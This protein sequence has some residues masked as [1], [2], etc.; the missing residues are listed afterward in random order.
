MIV[1]GGFLRL[2]PIK[3]RRLHRTGAKR[4]HGNPARAPLLR[5]RARKMLDRSFGTRINGIRIRVGGEQRRNDRDYFSTLAQG[6]SRFLQ[7]E[8][9]T[10]R[11]DRETLIVVLFRA[12]ENWF[13][14]HH[15]RGVDGDVHPAEAALG[16]GEQALVSR[17]LGEIALN[18]ERID[19][20]GFDRSDRLVR[21]RLRFGAVVMHDN[22]L[23]SVLREVPTD[24]TSEILRAAA[25][26]DNLILERVGHAPFCLVPINR[27]FQPTLRRHEFWIKMVYLTPLV[28]NSEQCDCRTMDKFESLRIFERVAEV[29][30]FTKAAEHLGLPRSTVSA[31]IMA[32]EARIGARLLNRTTRRV[33][34]TL[35]GAAFHQRCQKLLV[36]L[37]EAEM[38]FRRQTPPAGKLRITMPSRIGRLII[39]P[40][41]PT[42]FET[43]SKISIEICATDIV[44]D[45]VQ[46]DIDCALRVG[47]CNDDRL[48]HVPLGAL[49]IINCASPA[50]I[51]KHGFPRRVSDLSKHHAVHYRSSMIGGVDPWACVDQG[52]LHTIA[53]PSIVSTDDAETYIACALAGLGLIQIPAYDVQEHF[54][55]KELIEV[56]PSARAPSVPISLVYPQRRHL[57]RCL[58]AFIE[59]VT[60]VLQAR[61]SLK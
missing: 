43:H 31:A 10:L 7:E 32:L 22:G 49:E 36:D 59:W 38:L 23:R 60:P 1:G 47:E 9:G 35:D 8:E 12:V 24:E 54:S 55:R 19:A 46:D 21:R 30:S 25:N 27:S 48:I 18:R 56:L 51:E 37:E 44:R 42:F 16:L 50:Y 53:L 28:R 45:L 26:D 14:D 57:S 15:P 5:R 11:I 61:L 4:V 29:G 40:V 17:D 33:G 34:L 3:E 6:A 2:L 20:H 58:Q 13:L 52:K 39:A 41:L